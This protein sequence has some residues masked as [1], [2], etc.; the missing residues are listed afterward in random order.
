MKKWISLLSIIVL[1]LTML[2]LAPLPCA[3][4]AQPGEI[5]IGNPD[6]NNTINAADAL[7]LLRYSVGKTTLTPAQRS[8]GDVD[9][10]DQID[11]VDA[12]QILRMAVG[13][14]QQFEPT[15]LQNKTFT[16]GSAYAGQYNANT[17]FGTA[18][19]NAVKQVE[20][21][22]HVTID[23]V[24]LDPASLWMYD[25][26]ELPVHSCRQL[27]KQGSLLELSVNTVLDFKA[28]ES[29][30]T[31]SCTMGQ[32]VF[33]V[34]TDAMSAN[35]MGIAINADLLQRYAPNAAA[36]LTQQFE[37]GDWTWQALTALTDEYRQNN[38]GAACLIS[39]TNI[40]GQ[41]I[42]SN[43][44]YEVTFLEDGSSAVCSISS[45]EGIA[46][47]QYLKAMLNSGV[48]QY[49]AD[50]KVM[51][52]AFAEGR[53][54]MMVYYLSE[55]A[56]QKNFTLTAM[57]FPKGPNQNDYVM[58]T[59]NS[60]TFAVPDSWQATGNGAATL[61]NALAQADSSLA[62]AI[63][64]DAAALGFD[65]LGQEVFAWSAKHTSKDFSTGPFTA[66]VGGPVDGSVLDPSKDPAVELPAVAQ[67]I[68]Q[69]VDQY[70]GQF[71]V[72]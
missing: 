72:R 49:Q 46:A 51:K 65:T 52:Q 28:L 25:L 26:I 1:V 54:P 38:P 16:L 42:V 35:A 48:F 57:P 34:A 5:T 68:Q 50:I 71:Y 22:Y 69:E 45:H 44:G 9:C 15:G 53:V 13:K 6:G 59:F 39:N 56:V 24:E 3:A 37:K 64:Q 4:A 41:A 10:S 18:M 61:L 58:C 30:S 11:A 27:A 19:R 36:S 12:L 20:Q 62:A 31:G 43:A 63:E 67:L 29:G 21:R 55:A 60:R 8:A 14:I 17:A 47:M 66:A 2:P 23:I 32:S 7:L 33:G 40:I 70:Y